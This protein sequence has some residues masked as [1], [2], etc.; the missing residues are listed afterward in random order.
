MKYK[1]TDE[2]INFA[3]EFYIE[4]NAQKLLDK[5][6]AYLLLKVKKAVGQKTKLTYLRMEIVG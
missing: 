2:T 3:Q 5:K 1:I 6:L 4:L